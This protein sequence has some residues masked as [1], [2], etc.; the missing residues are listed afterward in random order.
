MHATGIMILFN[1]LWKYAIILKLIQL[2][3]IIAQ[4]LNDYRKCKSLMSNILLLLDTINGLG[5]KQL[6]S[7]NDI[8]VPL[9]YLAQFLPGYS[10][11]RAT[12]NTI[13]LL[14]GLGIPTG[15]LPDGSPNLMLL[16]NLMSN[17]GVDTERAENEVVQVV[18]TST[19]G[20][21]GK[22]R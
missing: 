13:E 2:A 16:Y 9:L 19:I 11:E 3:L 7:R 6:I 22:S 14:Q 20:G 17:K 10:P 4:L 12:I 1:C 15:T 8:P 18:L 5:P 21:V